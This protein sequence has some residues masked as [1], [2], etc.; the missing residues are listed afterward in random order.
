MI[1]KQKKKIV[2]CV[3]ITKHTLGHHNNSSNHYD[4]DDEKFGRGEEV[5]HEGCQFHTQAVDTGDQHWEDMITHE[6]I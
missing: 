5:L 3:Y 1:I 4:K 2:L 6:T